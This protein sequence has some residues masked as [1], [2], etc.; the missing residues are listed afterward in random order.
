MR[1]CLLGIPDAPIHTRLILEPL[2]PHE[3]LLNIGAFAVG[4][5]LYMR[6]E[7]LHFSDVPSPVNS[8]LNNPVWC[9]SIRSCRSDPSSVENQEFMPSER[10][11]EIR[12]SGW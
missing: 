5:N 4:Q 11:C 2:D 6:E 8:G 9:V 10:W 7:Y 12:H 3:N 1:G